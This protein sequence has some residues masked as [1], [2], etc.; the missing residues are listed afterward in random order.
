MSKLEPCKRCGALPVYDRVGN[1]LGCPNGH[2]RVATPAGKDSA[3]VWNRIQLSLKEGNDWDKPRKLSRKER[4]ER[5][6]ALRD[7]DMRRRVA[8]DLWEERMS[9]Y[10]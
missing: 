4:Q 6:D 2:F 3:V 5:F 8:A 7:A 10:E 9:I 1:A